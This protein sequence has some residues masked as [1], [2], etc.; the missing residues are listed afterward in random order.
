MRL[1]KVRESLIVTAYIGVK[2]MTG[3]FFGYANQE[4]QRLRCNAARRA[5][6]NQSFTNGG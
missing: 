6:D 1:P 2:G 3:R 4:A 5:R